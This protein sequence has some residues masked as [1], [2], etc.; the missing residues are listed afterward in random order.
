[1][2]QTSTT[3]EQLFNTETEAVPV[4]ISC[5]GEIT[6]SAISYD[7]GD[8][9]YLPL[10][11]AVEYGGV[12]A[13]LPII[14]A[15][16]D[17][18]LSFARTTFLGFGLAIEGENLD[19]I[20]ALDLSNEVI[21][22]TIDRPAATL[23]TSLTYEQL[24][25]AQTEAVSV[26]I[27][28]SE[29]IT[30]EKISYDPGDGQSLPLC[31]A[32]EYGGITVVL[33]V[34]LAPGNHSLSFVGATFSGFG[35]ALEGSN[36]DKITSLTLSNELPVRTREAIPDELL[37]PAGTPVYYV[38]DETIFANSEA[39]LLGPPTNQGPGYRVNDE[40]VFVNSE[41]VYIN[42]N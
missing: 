4:D 24:L 33:P 36:L 30:I 39:V 16:G 7:P 9:Q 35:L 29:E 28:C 38:N 12:P 13:V 26:D 42:T 31:Q 11:Q 20:T 40:T 23:Q 34:A 5:S 37:V 25:D 17:H 18:S 32:I 19:R 8:G 2:L 6:I 10:C 15:Q 1:M 3:C 21:I 27:S 14:L 41:T 22:P